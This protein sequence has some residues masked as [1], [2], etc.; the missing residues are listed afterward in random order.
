MSEDKQVNAPPRFRDAKGAEWEI[1]PTIGLAD[2]ILSATGFDPLEGATGQSAVELLF[3]SRKLCKVLWVATAAEAR[4]IS[5]EAFADA[6]NGDALTAGWGALVDAIIFFTP[7][8]NRAAA[9]AAIEMQVEAMEKGVEALV[10]VAM[11][12]ETSRGLRDAGNR[13]KD[14]MQDGLSK[15][16]AEFAGSLPA[17]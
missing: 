7:K 10:E 9:Q 15:V 3:D 17:S 1:N 13:V 2:R 5:L 12:A 11:S 4:Q 16:F 6:M 14:E 8:Q